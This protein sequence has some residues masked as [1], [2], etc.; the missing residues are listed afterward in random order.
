MV[1]YPLLQSNVYS[2]VSANS[3]VFNVVLTSMWKYFCCWF[4]EMIKLCYTSEWLLSCYCTSQSCDMK[5]YYTQETEF[6]CFT[7]CSVR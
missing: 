3:A 2:N 6:L 5:L 1:S 4:S 7:P